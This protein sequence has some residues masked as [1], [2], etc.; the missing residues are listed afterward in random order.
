MLQRRHK[1]VSKALSKL[2]SHERSLLA[3]LL[4]IEEREK[5]R[6]KSSVQIEVGNVVT[7]KIDNEMEYPSSL[8][9]LVHMLYLYIHGDMHTWVL[10][11]GAF[12]VTL[13]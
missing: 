5:K 8:H 1:F 11:L 4:K 12:Q 3:L 6:K 2:L 10:D 7:H 9:A 13:M